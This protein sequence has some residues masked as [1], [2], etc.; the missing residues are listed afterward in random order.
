MMSKKNIEKLISELVSD[1]RHGDDEAFEI[2]DS[3]LFEED[4]L[5]E[6][7]KKHFNIVD[8]QGWLANKIT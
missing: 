2:A 4:G 8:V 6:G 7:I 5:E 1:G 3:I